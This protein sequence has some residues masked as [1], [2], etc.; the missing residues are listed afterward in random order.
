[1]KVR[2]CPLCDQPM[3]KAHRCDNCHSF[4]WKPQYMDIHYNTDTV[5]GKDCS[6]DSKPHDYAYHDDGSVTMMPSRKRLKKEQQTQNFGQKEK[7]SYKDYQKTYRS[8][9]PV[10]K[11]N[12]SGKAKLIV[13]LLVVFGIISTAIEVIESF[14]EKV[15]FDITGAGADS[16]VSETQ[17]VY[18]EDDGDLSAGGEERRE[19]TDE[20]V[21]AGGKECTGI[22]H[23]EVTKDT[24]IAAVE[25]ELSALGVDIRSFSDE[26]NNYAY[27]YDD[28]YSY[29]YFVQERMYDM[30][31]D[32]GYYYNVSWD[33]FSKKLHEVSYNVCDSERAEAF[34]AAT[35]QALTGD[36]EKFRKEFGKQRETA[37]EDEYVF[38]ETEGY[39]IY[40]NYY[41]GYSKSY[42]VSIVKTM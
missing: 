16:V 37:E 11:R 35:M 19:Y 8:E 10:G 6:Y 21:I 36:G 14:T 3:K 41:K 22:A 27:E 24:F 40:I 1:M 42:Y 32:I 39:E 34:Y 26:S 2:I 30:D 23:M 38:F 25:P 13:I 15:S 12:A 18:D 17:W 29:T 7:E 4:V 28:D 33:T 5:H 20:E 9:T 31:M